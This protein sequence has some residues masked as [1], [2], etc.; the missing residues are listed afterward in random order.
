MF[1]IHPKTSYFSSSIHYL[2]KQSTALQNVTFHDH[3][4]SQN[5]SDN[6]YQDFIEHSYALC[7]FTENVG[8]KGMLCYNL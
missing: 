6:H 5:V 8:K 3:D 2:Q 7:E 1:G 4:Y